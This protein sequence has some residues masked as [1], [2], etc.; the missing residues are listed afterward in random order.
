MLEKREIEFQ[1][2]INI[3]VKLLIIIYK[4]KKNIIRNKFLTIH[5]NILTK[6]PIAR[7]KFNKFLKMV[8]I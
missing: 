3:D 4:T 5:N 1:N 8:K 2:D 6:I 7:K